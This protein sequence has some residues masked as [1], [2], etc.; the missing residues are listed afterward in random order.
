MPSAPLPFHTVLPPAGA[1]CAA[2]AR[3]LL[4]ALRRGGLLLLLLG[5]LTGCGEPEDGAAGTYRLDLTP[6]LEK[7][8]DMVE[9]GAPDPA[10]AR[11]LRMLARASVRLTLLE[12][13]TWTLKG[14][15]G[16][17][18]L[19]DAGRWQV[20]DGVLTLDYTMESSRPNE[21]RV[22]GTYAD[23]VVT[24]KPIPTMAEPHRFLRLDAAGGN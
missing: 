2:A 24:F 20:D 14:V 1:R 8:Q 16:N 6:F 18:E 7:A 17:T 23:G 5:S 3:L 21:R 4:R 10:Q 13:G 11:H 12:D 22:I 9:G 19:D 15:F